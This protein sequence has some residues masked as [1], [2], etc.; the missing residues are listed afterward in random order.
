MELKKFDGVV[1]TDKVNEDKGHEKRKD[2]K[3]NQWLV[4]SNDVRE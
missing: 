3:W 2:N 1:M 4:G